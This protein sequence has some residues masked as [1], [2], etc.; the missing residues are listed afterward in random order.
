MAARGCVS[1]REY[2]VANIFDDAVYPRMKE[3][4]LLNALDELVVPV[5]KVGAPHFRRMGKA[6]FGKRIGRTENNP[7]HN[8]CVR[9][10]HEQLSDTDVTRVSISTYLFSE[11]AREEQ[12]IFSTLPGSDYRW[13]MEADARIAFENDTY[14]QPDL[15]GRD[16]N[17]FFPRASCPNIIIEVIRTHEPEEE[18]FNRLYELSRTNTLVVFYVIGE[19]SRG[20]KL[21]NFRR[22]GEELTLRI[23]HYLIAGQPYVNGVAVKA[24]GEDE[25]LAHWHKYLTNSYFKKAKE[26]AS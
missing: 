2:S 11:G 26:S 22:N 3:E 8:E 5:R 7:T 12:V 25:T 17:R 1:G 13:F 14:I 16:A 6:S 4:P 15:S 10:L 9:V 18:T 19:G 23:S 20:G 24:L 21:N